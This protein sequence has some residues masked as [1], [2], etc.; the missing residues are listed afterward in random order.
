M[1]LAGFL[2]GGCAS[3]ED[4]GDAAAADSSAVDSTARAENKKPKK[5]RSVSVNAARV[6][7]DDLIVPVVAE[8]AVRA[9][10]RTEVRAEIAGRLDRVHVME[11]RRVKKG[12]LIA[13]LDDRE[14]RIA[15]EEANAKYLEALGRLA[16]DDET[17]DSKKATIQ[18]ED[19]IQKL[20]EMYKAG[21]ITLVEK[22][23]RQVAVEVGAVKEGAYRGELVK[24]R[25]GLTAARAA[26][27]RA[28]LDLE[29]TRIRAPFTG[30][31][32]GLDLT[33][34][35]RLS[36]NQVLCELVDNHNLEAEISVL[37]S[38]LRGIEEG[39]P[40]RLQVPALD[41]QILGRVDVMGSTID[42][43]SRTCR[44]LVRFDNQDGHVRPGMFVR[45]SIAGDTFPDLLQVPRESI[46]TRDG[47]PLLFKVEDNHALWVYVKT[48]R[49]NDRMVEI[50]KILQGGPLEPG[51]LAVVSNHLTLTHN[52]KIKVKKVLETELA[53]T[54]DEKAGN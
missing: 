35:E 20:E 48:G 37:E 46:L 53:W 10:N 22:Q 41:L 3:G 50:E 16:A 1:L 19:E 39:R 44:L 29:Y 21:T 25:S 52:A 4:A 51:T 36:M 54:A 9:R 5:E 42:P 34:G 7:R 26:K 43:Q 30:V 13:S 27:E 8:G 24:V 6:I 2:L 18:L 47:R 17:L 32:N 15:M 33:A 49:S 28:E 23:E 11:G 31:V 12:Q 40:V 14:Y 45:A 38:D